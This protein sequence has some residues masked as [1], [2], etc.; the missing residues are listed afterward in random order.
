MSPLP[1]SC[2][3]PTATL[4]LSHIARVTPHIKAINE[5]KHHS[6]TK[7]HL[8]MLQNPPALTELSLGTSFQFN[9]TMPHQLSAMTSLLGFEHRRRA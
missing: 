9:G 1:L 3:S 6:F 2:F 7:K 8:S 4:T 5:S